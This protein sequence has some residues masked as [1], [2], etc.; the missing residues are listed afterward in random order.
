VRK[1]KG[2]KTPVARL[3]AHF[4]SSGPGLRSLFPFESGASRRFIAVNMIRFLAPIAAVLAAV[5]AYAGTL[6]DVH[7]PIG[8]IRIELY[9]QDKPITVQNFLS[10]I[11]SGR[12]RNSFFH[13]L[14]PG[15]IVQGGGFR[16]VQTESENTLDAVQTFAP[17]E[18]EYSAGTTYSN[19]YGTV[20][21]ARVGGDINSAT[22]QWFINLTDNAFLDTVDEGFTV[23]GH[24]VSGFEVLERFNTTFADENY[25]VD[26]VFD[27]TEYLDGPFGELPLLSNSLVVENFLFT[28]I[29]V[30]VPDVIKPTAKIKSP[31]K[32]TVVTSKPRLRIAGIASDNEEVKV[33]YVR[34]GKGKWTKARGTAKWKATIRLKAE[35]TV[36]QVRAEDA[37][38]NTSKIRKVTARL[39]R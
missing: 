29:E 5:P 1:T 35:R 21:M 14:D 37:A 25:Q 39:E 15:F 18:N 3:D 33:V 17:I 9:D 31:A 22:S 38:G 34:A 24:V 16:I 13:R 7:T 8:T 12:Y 26:G 30:V 19:L 32:R 6:V 27:A 28:N 2:E 11:E 20:A 36:I 4:P 10:Y 23:F